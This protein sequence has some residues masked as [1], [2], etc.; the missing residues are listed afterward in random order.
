MMMTMKNTTM[1]TP[2]PRP[3]I[4]RIRRALSRS[5][6]TGSQI[7]SFL[8]LTCLALPC[9]A[10]YQK[11]RLQGE[12]S[13]LVTAC[14]GYKTEYGKFPSGTNIEIMR[15]LTGTNPRKFTF[16]ELP[17]RSKDAD[18]CFL[19]QWGTPYRV[20]FPNAETLEIRSAG[21][22][23]VFDTADDKYLRKGPDGIDDKT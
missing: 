8:C 10:Q 19:D 2:F 14:T 9:S 15:A 7:A 11:T 20:V 3:H 4:S 5:R 6:P 17:A 13:Q 16:I 12:V 1:I 18:G 23:K 22:D 21:A